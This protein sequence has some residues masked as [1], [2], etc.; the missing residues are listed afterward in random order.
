[1]GLHSKPD[2]EGVNGARSDM[3]MVII[4]QDEGSVTCNWNWSG[5]YK[6]VFGD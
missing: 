6:R 5:K 1:M 4:V 2:R 3:E